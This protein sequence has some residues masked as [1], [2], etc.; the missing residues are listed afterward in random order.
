MRISLTNTLQ[1]SKLLLLTAIISISC[2]LG[3]LPTGQA[4]AACAA[5]P[6]DK[7]VDT[8][9]TSVPTDG[10][11]RVWSRIM[12]PD[13]TNNSFLLQIDNTTCSVIVGDSAIPA[14]TWTWVDYSA[15][16][17]ATKINVA[18]TAGAHTVVMA[19]RESSVKV[20]RVELVAD[21]SCVPTGTGDNCATAAALKPDVT[22]TSVG[23]TTTTAGNATK[24][25]ATIKNQGSAAVPAGTLIGVAFSIDGGATV[26]SNE[27]N[28][29][30]L[31]AGASLTLTAT[32]PWTA[33]LGTH[34]V[35]A[36]VDDTNVIDE[37]DGTN[38]KLSSTITVAPASTTSLTADIN[39]DGHVNTL[40][41]AVILTHDN[42]NYA[43]ADL[44]HDGTVGAADLAILLS[45]WV[46]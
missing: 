32:A 20:D 18:L 40:D 39:G 25:T 41:L 29:S 6:T 1:R 16:N 8:V 15:G 13:T 37:A 30:G 19:G 5:L 45:H 4:A 38:N 3:L 17:S 23:P 9:S 24:F 26:S 43:P 46:W 31:A 22:V 2:V 10:T 35:Q 7:G 28:T 14:N 33:V 36:Y 27:T 44:N 21:T 34:T 11:Y 42:T 12:A